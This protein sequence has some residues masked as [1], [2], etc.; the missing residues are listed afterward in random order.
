MIYTYALLFVRNNLVR[1][2]S[3]NIKDGTPILEAANIL[4]GK[5][6]KLAF[7]VIQNDETLYWFI[8]ETIYQ[9]M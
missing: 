9:D 6:Y 7:V 5:Q 1:A 4:G 8:K 2:N 3:E